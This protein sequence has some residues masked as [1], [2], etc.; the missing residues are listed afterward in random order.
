M[1][2]DHWPVFRICTGITCIFYGFGSRVNSVNGSGS[3]LFSI[4]FEVYDLFKCVFV[5]GSGSEGHRIGIREHCFGRPIFVIPGPACQRSGMITSTGSRRT[6]CSRCSSSSSASRPSWA[7]RRGPPTAPPLRDLPTRTT[8]STS[9]D[10]RLL[11]RRRRQLGGCHCPT[12]RPATKIVSAASNCDW[13]SISKKSWLDNR[14]KSRNKSALAEYLCWLFDG[15][16]FKTFV[17][18]LIYWMLYFL[19]IIVELYFIAVA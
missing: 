1:Y 2:Y 19:K 16:L 15:K 6:F 14:R 5:H 7:R 9:S 17:H 8:P 4:S 10:R 18:F 12:L 3:S 11:P 13:L